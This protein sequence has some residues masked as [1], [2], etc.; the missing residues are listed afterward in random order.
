MGALLMRSYVRPA[1]GHGSVL[2]MSEE[3]QFLLVSVLA[4]VGAGCVETLCWTML[5]GR[6][7]QRRG[8][9]V[10]VGV[11]A[12]SV[13]GATMGLGLSGFDVTARL[14]CALLAVFAWAYLRWRLN[15]PDRLMQAGL[16]TAGTKSTKIR[17][18]GR[19]GPVRPRSG[20]H[21][22][23]IVVVI[24]AAPVASAILYPDMRLYA[25]VWA[26]VVAVPAG[27]ILWRRFAASGRRS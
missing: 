1:R 21:L 23:L 25:L 18:P 19:V 13:A 22:M 14:T 7:V 9:R 6:D 26:A 4:L 2:A 8:M 10:W 20:K 15:V 17:D 11:L 5:A 16:D 27:I 24:V 12:V 3:M